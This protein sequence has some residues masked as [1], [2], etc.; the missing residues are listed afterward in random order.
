MVDAENRRTGAAA[1]QEVRRLRLIHRASYVFVFNSGGDLF[2]HRRAPTKDVY[3]G[4]WDP[5]AGGVVLDGESYEQTARRELAEELGI[6]DVPLTYDFTFYH[7]DGGNRVWGAVYHC[8]HDGPLTLQEEE[9]DRGAFLPLD[10][11]LDL[12][13]H[14]P[15]TP[16][17]LRAMRR[18]LELLG[19]ARGGGSGRLGV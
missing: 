5:A 18:L 8:T 6:R 13:S 10:Q 19:A 4:H 12:A 15:F 7:E 1:R 16:D 9:I 2:V 11:T 3:P 17:G 14:A